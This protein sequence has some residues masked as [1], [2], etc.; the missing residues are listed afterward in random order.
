MAA[1]TTQ[2]EV[3]DEM[4]PQAL[5][6][7]HKFGLV[8]K[9]ESCRVAWSVTEA[10]RVTL[11]DMRGAWPSSIGERSRIAVQTMIEGDCTKVTITATM[12]PIP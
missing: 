8:T 3:S 4:L 6:W 11:Q 2:I 9:I 5:P 1:R 12:E 7:L 10:W